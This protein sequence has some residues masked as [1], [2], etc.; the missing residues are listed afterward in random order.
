M[1]ESALTP[2]QRAARAAL[3]FVRSETVIGLGSGS[4]AECFL[5]ALAQALESGRLRDV[6]GVPTSE[7]TAR[8][9][10][11]LGIP[12]L[13]LADLEEPLD[14]TVD[15]A[16]EVSP[17]LDLIKGLGGALL[18]E[19]IVAEN[20]RSLIVIA[21]AGKRVERLGTK[22]PVPVEV[23]QFAHQATARYLATL[24]CNP[25]LRLKPDG[26]PFVTD[27]ANVIY[28]CHFAGGIADPRSLQSSLCSRA[29]VMETGLF[30]GFA[31]VA[32]L[33]D[34]GGHVQTLRRG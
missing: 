13:D 11:E 1:S 4:T 23:A 14:V 26:Q 27:N 17:D 22:S 12:L 28:D 8:Q 24:G 2:K 7:K 29:G 16:D 15:G 32:L 25:K 34:E 30:L 3:D 5:F 18:R 6:G 31:K 21:D 19:K 10:R 9:A 33:A 20:T